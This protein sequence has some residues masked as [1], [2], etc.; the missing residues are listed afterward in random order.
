MKRL[1]NLN[2]FRGTLPYASEIFGVYQPLLGWKS[3]R[4]LRRFE[5]GYF[6]DQL[7]ILDII[8][9]K[10]KGDYKLDIDENL[11]LGKV[12]KIGVAG[13]LGNQFAGSEILN[14][15]METLPVRGEVSNEE[16]KAT[17]NREFM[18]KILNT[19]VKPSL[20]KLAE[21][22]PQLSLASKGAA[23]SEPKIQML[24]AKMNRESVVAGLLTYLADNNHFELLKKLIDKPKRE[25][26]S[27]LGILNFSN[28][29]DYMDPKNDLER[30]GLS[31]IG[32]V[33]LFRQY[34]FEF[35]TFLGSPVGHI[36]LSP[37]SSVELYEVS[38]RKVI[39]EK[40]LE[41]QFES[42]AKSETTVM[43]QDELSDAVKEDNKNEVKFGATVSASENWVWGSAS[44]TASFDMNKS[45][46]TT[47][48]QAHKHMRQQSEKLSTEI[49]K[50]YK[51][52]FKTTIEETDT[53]S[54]RYL[55]SN[56]TEEL[57]NYELRRKMRQVGVQ[58]QDIGTYLCW[59][60]Y[61]DEPGHN[62][63]VA[64]L[65]HVAQSP[66]FDQIPHPEA[67]V[68]KKAFVE[69]VDI[70]ISFV[71]K[72]TDDKD[73]PFTDG[74]NTDYFDE[75]IDCEF[76][77][78]VTCKEIDYFL[79]D[80]TLQAP[81][82]ELKAS[83]RNL[84]ATNTSNTGSFTIYL[85]YVHFHGQNTVNI[86]ASLHWKPNQ[87]EAAIKAA[88]ATNMS[89]YKEKVESAYKKKFI[90]AARDRIKAASNIQPRKYEDLREEERISVYR[91]LIQDLLV[92]EDKISQPD[93][94]TRHIVSEL[95][96][97]I[98]DVDKML[99]FVS[100]EWWKPRQ[101]YSQSFGTLKSTGKTGSDGLPEMEADFTNQI[102][103][104]NLVGW[105][106]VNEK[107]YDN[108]YITEESMPAKQGSSLG[109]LLQLDGDNQRNAFLNAPWVKS[110]IPIRP[111]QERA[112]LNWLK[113]IDGVN[114]ITPDDMYSGR[115]RRRI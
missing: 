33:H 42:I 111:G 103:S 91:R 50:N 71:G 89:K 96:N 67:I 77:Q 75:H 73:Q 86:E 16:L 41:T 107:R 36:W 48:E 80:V 15:I 54:K 6:N 95:V 43:E 105:G 57:I 20:M 97:S 115:P 26:S 18:T 28:P 9:S 100:P 55:L 10:L 85:D 79:A 32:I 11:V 108:Y 74:A 83:V 49:R 19:N 25:A 101:H 4:A 68:A 34:F 61:V 78:K 62:L 110:V 40:I 29:F 112:A 31:P 35:E 39:T 27:L 47:R 8:A 106:R 52:T 84:T 99:Y 60:T 69:K 21:A 66:D 72:D 102:T 46:Q 38:T 76:P 58:V 114:G 37:G 12:S 51:S 2:D 93:Y 81:G 56:N 98:F 1:N 113:Q 22:Q 90:E 109:W 7:R 5:K 3:T 17:L 45:Q 13:I 44:Q 63:G 14:H 104:E 87:D 59:Q 82:A 94:R 30:V 70:P 92:P 53:Y 24:R 64:N 23:A 65:V 88:N